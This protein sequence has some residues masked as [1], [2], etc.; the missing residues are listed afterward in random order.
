MYKVW[1][2]AYKGLSGK[3]RKAAVIT[4]SDLSYEDALLQ[5]AKE[6]K[7][8]MHTKDGNVYWLGLQLFADE[9]A[10]NENIFNIDDYAR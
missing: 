1:R 6:K 7:T 3:T 4:S 8:E 2:Q 10:A 5:F 9:D